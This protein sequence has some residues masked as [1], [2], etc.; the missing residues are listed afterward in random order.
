MA[1]LLTTLH[2][3]RE[4]IEMENTVAEKKQKIEDVTPGFEN[5][6]KQ[7][8]ERKNAYEKQKKDI[9]GMWYESFQLGVS[10]DTCY[11]VTAAM[12]FPLAYHNTALLR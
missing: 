10:G 9:V 6:E 12:D 1:I 7:F 2:W 4:I 5:L 11:L 3:Q 8:E